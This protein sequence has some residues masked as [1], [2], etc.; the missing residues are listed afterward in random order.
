MTPLFNTL[1]VASDFSPPSDAAVAYAGRLAQHHQA[2]LLL[3]HIVELHG[4]LHED[5]ELRRPGTAESVRAGDYARAEAEANLQSQIQRLVPA[6]V[7]AVPVVLFGHPVE[8]IAHHA[9]ELGADLIVVGTH[10]RRGLSRALL[11]S[12]A[13]RT[14]RLSTLPVLT[15]RAP[16]PHP[17]EAPA[18]AL[19]DEEQG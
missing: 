4:G 13:E 6:S 10:G 19:D 3:L 8:C 12:V 9:P 15:V 1:L 17:A 7:E 16:A 5:T 11:G 14:V 2:R 18:S